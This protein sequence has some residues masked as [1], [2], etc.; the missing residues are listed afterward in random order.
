MMA[1]ELLQREQATELLREALS[2]HTVDGAELTVL[3]S[4]ELTS[5]VHRRR[6]VQYTVAGLDA[7]GPTLLIAK[8]FAESSVPCFSPSICRC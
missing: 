6:V 3:A 4:Q 7:A 8:T 1:T 2:Q 5:A